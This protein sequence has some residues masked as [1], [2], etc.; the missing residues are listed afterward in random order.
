MGTALGIVILIVGLFAWIGQS[1]AFL[2]P[3]LAVKLGVLEPKGQIDPTL[4]VI[5]AKAEGLTDM[6]LTWT[7]PLSALLMLLGHPLWP[8]LGLIGG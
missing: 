3:S 7:L 2:A 1:L 8:Y 4:Y 6:L 5:E